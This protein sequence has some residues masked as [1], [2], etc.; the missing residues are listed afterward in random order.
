MFETNNICTALNEFE[1]KAVH[2][3]GVDNRIADHLPMWH[4]N[5]SHTKTFVEITKEVT[6]HNSFVQEKDFIFIN[7]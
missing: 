6:L 2:I 7:P 1:I 5:E 4:L 3:S